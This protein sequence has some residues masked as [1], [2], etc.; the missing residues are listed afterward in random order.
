MDIKETAAQFALKE[1]APVAKPDFISILRKAGTA[2]ICGV[3]LPEPYGG[4]GGGYPEIIALAKGLA[5]HGGDA[6]MAFS[7]MYHLSVSRFMLL[8]FGTDAQ[9]SK[10]LPELAAGGTTL[11]FAVSEPGIG[12]H[13]KHLKAAAERDNG[14][15]II[16]GE[17]TYVSNGPV[18]D[19]F[20]IVAATASEGNRKQ[21]TA[22]LTGRDAPGLNLTP[23]DVGWLKSSPHC[24]LR[25]DGCRVPDSA[26]VGTPGK[27]YPDIVMPFR[28][29]ED[30]LTT[31]LICGGLERLFA[32]A[33][34]RLKSSGTAG[35]DELKDSV[36]RLYSIL[37]A[38]QAVCLRTATVLDSQGLNR[39]LEGLCFWFREM[40]RE[41]MSL[42]S[43]LPGQEENAFGKDIRKLVDLGKNVSFLRQ[44]KTG[45]TLLQER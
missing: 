15:Y 1:I 13:P 14:S 21:F 37:A 35:T 9:R 10:L 39:E 17:K 25:L 36:G 31:G 45:G 40:A 42:L 34:D 32:A 28:P 41:F 2:G 24:G 5:R 12:A 26:V 27:A 43:S 20:I 30:A 3:G 19:H 38:M 8:G 18:A 44:A 6:G 29:L 11:C 33:L 16:R 23:L 22:F 7:L 4:S